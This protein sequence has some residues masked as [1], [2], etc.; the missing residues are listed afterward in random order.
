MNKYILIFLL[1]MCKTEAQTSV[2]Q[3]ADSLFNNGNYSKAI[4]HYKNHTPQEEVFYKMA[5]AYM[6]LGNYD[7]ALLNLESAI[8]SNPEN[9][10]LKYDY[11]KL[12]S[13][14]RKSNKALAVFNELVAIDP[15]NPNYHYE[16]GLVLEPTKD[17]LAQT[18]YVKAFQLDQTHQKAIYKIGKY[19]LTKRKHETADSI[20]DIGLKTYANNIELISLKA[21]N[22]FWQEYYTKAIT[23]FEKLIET[24]ESSEFIFEKLS[25][26]YAQ[27]YDYE[28][29]LEY[30]LKALKYNPND[31]VA[32]YVIGTYYEKLN[33]LEKAEKYIN[34]A[35]LI[36]DKPLDAE[37]AKLATVLNR[38][39]KYKESIVA[40]KKSIN[41][42]P[43]NE[44]SHLQLAMTL[45]EY[46]ADYDAKIDAFE[47]FK[48][49]FPN[50]KLN[51]YVD[52]YISKLKEEKFIKEGENKD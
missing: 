39:K 3:F 12:L 5:K 52:G 47:K 9:T 19:Y 10:L 26:S 44:F 27:N 36:L 35:L 28:K 41:E 4:E 29:A 37:Y 8:K 51:D 22:Y 14:T 17:S 24:G 7:E 48:Q 16:L 49:K 11:A 43:S 18:H 21:Q 33:D 25:I 38:Q 23:W 1:V 46:Y 42:D 2:L 15:S 45:Q 6:A 32:R 20:I 50:S 31:A 30:R 13:A 40:L 34:D